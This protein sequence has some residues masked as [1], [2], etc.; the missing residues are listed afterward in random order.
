[1]LGE[2]GF[3]SFTENLPML[4]SVDVACEGVKKF[5]FR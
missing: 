2:F 4:K 1:M 5:V 3:Q